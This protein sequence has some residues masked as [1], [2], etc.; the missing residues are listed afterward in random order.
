MAVRELLSPFDTVVTKGMLEQAFYALIERPNDKDEKKEIY[1]NAIDLLHKKLRKKN[2][3]ERSA[4]K[5]Q[6]FLLSRVPEIEKGQ[7]TLE[8]S[9][10]FS[11]ATAQEM[12]EY[13]DNRPSPEPIPD[14]VVRNVA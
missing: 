6:R 2:I 12:K 3:S 5:I 8:E 7:I 13:Y 4:K 10:E 11:K 9:R 14:I 1:I